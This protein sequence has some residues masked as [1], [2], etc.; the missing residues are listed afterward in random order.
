ML[1]LDDLKGIARE[2]ISVESEKKNIPV[3][4][5][6]FATL[7]YYNSAYFK[8]SLKEG[9]PLI[10]L[11]F[12][13]GGFVPSDAPIIILF[14][15]Q[16]RSY[17]RNN[18]QKYVLYIK[19]VYHEFKHILQNHSHDFSYENCISFIEFIVRYDR[20]Y[21]SKYHDSFLNENDADLYGINMA[22]DF[23]VKKN[24]LTPNI[25]KYI[26]S[27]KQNFEFRYNNFNPY[28]LLEKFNEMIKGK[29]RSKYC[30]DSFL[31]HSF[32]ELFMIVKEIIKS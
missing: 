16:Y 2:I 29:N 15:D 20:G 17:L 13:A 6:C 31:N 19:T 10:L 22:Y 28:K 18:M 5:F 11:P 3:S 8:Q 21:Y 32:F 23:F 7:E 27:I 9:N 26:E 1:K 24:M 4:L 25:K 30:L 14:P 12:I